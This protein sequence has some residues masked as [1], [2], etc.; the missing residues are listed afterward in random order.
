M[1]SC[2]MTESR[3]GC[4]MRAGYSVKRWAVRCRS[5][6]CIAY[7][8]HSF[9]GQYT[10][11]IKWM[12]DP[13]KCSLS[14]A[15]YSRINIIISGAHLLYLLNP[16][17]VSFCSEA[18]LSNIKKNNYVTNVITYSPQIMKSMDSG[19]DRFRSLRTCCH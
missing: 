9:P 11:L 1:G 12:P 4:I 6:G 19:V 18:M 3:H 5:I 15:I 8:L 10:S 14:S 7:E 17:N 2:S 13:E 16:R